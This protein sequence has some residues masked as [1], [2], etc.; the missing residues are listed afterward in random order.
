MSTGDVICKH[1]KSGRSFVAGKEGTG[2]A[3]D[4]LPKKLTLFVTVHRGTPHFVGGV[5]AVRVGIAPE[6]IRDAMPRMA[7]ELVRRARAI[8]LVTK[9]PAIILS[10]T[11][12]RRQDTAIRKKETHDLLLTITSQFTLNYYN[13]A[14]LGVWNRKIEH[15]T[16]LIAV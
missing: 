16:I 14:R 2:G 3:R 12:C 11:S 13:S 1:E 15:I 8:R 7:A 6:V 9:I 5:W 4:K 10:I